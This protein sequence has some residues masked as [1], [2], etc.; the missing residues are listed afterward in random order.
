MYTYSRKL[1]FDPTVEEAV[2]PFSIEEQRL[3]L[4]ACDSPDYR[5]FIQFALWTGLRTSELI[6]LD[7]NDIDWARGVVRVRKAMTFDAHGTAEDTKTAAGR[8][9]VKLLQPAL[10]AL[11]AQKSRT[12]LAGK[13]IFQSP[14]RS[15]AGLAT[16]Q[17]WDIWQGVA[18]RA[19][20]RYRV[21]YQTRHT[22]A[23][24]M[25]SAGEHP[26]WVA[27]QMGHA[28]WTMIAKVYGK[29]MPDADVG[30]GGRAVTKFAASAAVSEAWHSSGK[31]GG[32]GGA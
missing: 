26:M 19:K 16:N 23:S 21:P 7:W 5:N 8:R 29:W 30:A 12:Y 9:D 25:L 22:F 31:T 6:A 27:K 24:M 18:R 28:D 17:I 2:D 15:S 20:V 13:N 1:P 4:D 11:I 10:D 14:G 32:N 3:I